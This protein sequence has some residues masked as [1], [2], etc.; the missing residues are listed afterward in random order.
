MQDKLALLQSKIIKKDDIAQLL[1]IWNF[2]N[3]KIVFTNGCFDVL[4]RGHVHYLAKASE[5]GSKLII[6][7]NSDSSVRRLKGENRPIND[8]ESRAVVLASLSFIDAIVYF[9]EDTPFNLIKSIQPD[10]LVKGGDYEIKDIVGYDIVT[11]KGGDVVTIDFVN[12]F[13]STSIIKKG[14][15]T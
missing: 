13:S 7:L 3:E 1:S 4:H 14:H 2:K 8:E 12:G 10:V 5:L 9:E 6:G 15:L 11:N